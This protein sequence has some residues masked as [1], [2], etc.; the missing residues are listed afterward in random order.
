MFKYQKHHTPALVASSSRLPSAGGT[1]WSG[2]GWSSRQSGGGNLRDLLG[3][4]SSNCFPS[5]SPSSS[6]YCS[7][8][9]RLVD[10]ALPRELPA[11]LLHRLANHL[12]LKLEGGL[13]KG[14][15]EMRV[16]IDLVLLH[17][18]SDVC[19]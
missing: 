4:S 8:S 2:G 11:D 18:C 12:V 6:C 7:T 5:T 17:L 10:A 13:G 1:G 16:L 9:K 15:R 14:G 3:L 19:L